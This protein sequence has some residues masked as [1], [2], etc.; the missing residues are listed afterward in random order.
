VSKG[1]HRSYSSASRCRADTPDRHSLA[2][3][4]PGDPVAEQVAGI[5]D[6]P[7]VGRGGCLDT[8]HPAASAE[9][10][11]VLDIPPPE[12]MCAGASEDVG[13]GPPIQVPAD[14]IP[15]IRF[16]LHVLVHRVRV[17]LYATGQ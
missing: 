9:T 1:I 5:G 12:G 2:A 17:L 3:I 6:R 10:P 11:G 8:V 15:T 16:S 14:V 13:L 7:P 4:P